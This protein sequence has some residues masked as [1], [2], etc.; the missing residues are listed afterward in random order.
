MKKLLKHSMASLALAVL[1]ACGGGSSP[2]TVQGNLPP[3]EATLTSAVKV[4]NASQMQDLIATSI[5]DDNQQSTLTVTTNSALA[6]LAVGQIAFLPPKEADG[7]EVFVKVEG[8]AEVNGQTQLAVSVPAPHEVF[9]KIVFNTANQ[10]G[11]STRQVRTVF[12]PPWVK[13]EENAFVSAMRQV[14]VLDKFPNVV[15][16]A[17]TEEY[18]LEI[19]L[20]S[21][22]KDNYKGTWIVEQGC[23][24][25]LEFE[26]WKQ[27]S[28]KFK[29]MQEHCTRPVAI[30][31]KFKHKSDDPITSFEATKK[32]DKLEFDANKDHYIKSS[33]TISGEIGVEAEGEVSL[34]DLFSKFTHEEM[35]G[36]LSGFTLGKKDGLAYAQFSGLS[37]DDKKGKIPLVGVVATFAPVPV[38]PVTGPTSAAQIKAT[39]HASFLAQCRIAWNLTLSTSV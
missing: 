6:N 31:G 10:T 20:P 4:M 7:Q 19:P 34:S 37:S 21:T 27:Y 24:K 28:T 23:A 33:T 32:G 15:Y 29:W 14:G 16:D 25:P 3:P 1:A 12:L 39:A 36:D 22:A 17:T 30:K 9:E 38:I 2:A 13:K 26:D 8:K 18:S 5:V 11:L 35:F